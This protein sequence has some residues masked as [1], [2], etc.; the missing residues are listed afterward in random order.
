MLPIERI[1]V[2]SAHFALFLARFGA[3]QG[4]KMKRLAPLLLLL[5]PFAAL[6]QGSA[7]PAASAPAAASPTPAAQPAV[8]TTPPATP[9]PA[10]AGSTTSSAHATPSPA[11]AATII[12][13]RPKRLMDATFK[14]S[15]YVDDSTIGRIG[16]GENFKVKVAP[17]S[18]RI[19]S[20]DK[21]TGLQLDAKDG[22]TYYIR[23]DMKTG[24]TA[25]GAVTKV[26]KGEGS[27]EV[28]QTK[29]TIDVDL[30]HAPGPPP[31]STL[32]PP[33]Q[34]PSMGPPLTP[35]PPQP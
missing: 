22:E 33:G 25:R 26:D 8:A 32:A 13:Y 20:N 19:Y 9:A 11:G 34:Q 1:L 4:Q 2:R 12:F 30:S 7:A 27:V 5:I 24:L 29:Q 16:N 31:P 28:A 23:V 35:T 21:S 10:T 3:R 17:G 14:P 18:H 6:G 15:V